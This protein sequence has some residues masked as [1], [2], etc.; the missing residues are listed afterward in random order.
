VVPRIMAAR[1]TKRV[2]RI[3]L[4]LEIPLDS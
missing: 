1:L 4:D 3:L 2:S